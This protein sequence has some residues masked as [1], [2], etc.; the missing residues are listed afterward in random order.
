MQKLT[1][2]EDSGI[3]EQDLSK[4]KIIFPLQDKGEK[5]N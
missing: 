4:T 3:F 1:F 2:Q 5:D